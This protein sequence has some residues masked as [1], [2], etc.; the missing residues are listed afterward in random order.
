MSTRLLIHPTDLRT[1]QAGGFSEGSGPVQQST[2][3]QLPARIY[4]VSRRMSRSA[5]S[6]PTF[7][8]L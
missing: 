2:E 5:R 7:C 6:Q 8:G 3:A 4:T 1:G